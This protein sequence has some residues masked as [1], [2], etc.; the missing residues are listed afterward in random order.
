MDSMLLDERNFEVPASQE[1]VWRLIGKVIFSSLPGLERM[2]ILDENNFRGLLRIRVLGFQVTLKLKGEILDVEPPDSF[3][4][5]LFLEGP[6]GMFE[7]GQKVAFTM[8][9]IGAEK[10]RV[11]C[12]AVIEEIGFLP[13]LLVKGQARRFA[14][15]TFEA[16]EKRLKQLA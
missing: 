3:S 11:V 14:R 16:I 13:G 6:G 4:A 8:T 12:K 10:T 9:P 15:S 2:E 7:A 5:K 1:R